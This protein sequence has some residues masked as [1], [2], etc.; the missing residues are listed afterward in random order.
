MKSKLTLLAAVILAGIGSTVA[1]AGLDTATPS[2]P[3]ADKPAAKSCCAMKET[4][5][6]TSAD[7]DAA[8]GMSCHSNAPAAKEVTAAKS[9]GCCK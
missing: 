8:S 2:T 6:A 4:A 5:P 9:K 3:A 1:I 7:K